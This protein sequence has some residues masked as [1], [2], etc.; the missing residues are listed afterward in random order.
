MRHARQAAKALPE[1]RRARHKRKTHMVLWRFTRASVLFRT[2][3]KVPWVISKFQ[4]IS[5]TITRPLSGRLTVLL[6]AKLPTVFSSSCLRRPTLAERLRVNGSLLTSQGFH[7]GDAE[8]KAITRVHAATW[9]RHLVVGKDSG[10]CRTSS[11]EYTKTID[12]CYVLRVSPLLVSPSCCQAKQYASQRKQTTGDAVEGLRGVMNSLYTV[13]AVCI[14]LEDAL[15]PNSHT[16]VQY[17][18]DSTVTPLH[19]TTRRTYTY[20]PSAPA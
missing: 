2:S 1:E 10:K 4:Q 13:C 14:C 15:T 7:Q 9:T 8:D 5:I 3:A 17:R 19:V 11:K 18:T 12:V 6:S 16:T 20:P